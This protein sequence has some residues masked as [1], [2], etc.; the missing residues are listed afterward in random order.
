[1]V[2]SEDFFN[3]NIQLIARIPG[4]IFIKHKNPEH[5]KMRTTA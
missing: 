3:E 5:Q 4:L 2:L 1:V